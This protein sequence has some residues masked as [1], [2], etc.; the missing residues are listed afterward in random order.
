MPKIVTAAQMKKLDRITE[1]RY[2][3]PGVVLME[4]AGR[5]SASDSKK[6][7]RPYSVG[8]AITAVMGL[9]AAATS[10]EAA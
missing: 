2:G 7:K 1:E 10:C 3:I 6:E 4:N 8:R 9:S 5:E